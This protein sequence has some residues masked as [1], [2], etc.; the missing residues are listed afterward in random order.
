M[1]PRWLVAAIKG[2][3]DLE[4]FVIGLGGRKKKGAKGS[5]AK[6]RV[7]T[8]SKKAKPKASQSAKEKTASPAD[9]PVTAQQ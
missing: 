4:D 3:A 8:K 7:S 6:K 5:S 9:A 1:T 2:G